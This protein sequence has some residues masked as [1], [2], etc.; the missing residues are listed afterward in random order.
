M[1]IILLKK[2]VKRIAGRQA[3][4]YLLNT[5]LGLLLHDKLHSSSSTSRDF[6]LQTLPKFSICAEIGVNEGDF[7]ER[8]LEIV[9]PKKLHL[10][11]PWKF[12]DDEFYKTTPYGSEKIQDQKMLDIRFENVTKR[13]TTE[14][15][16][17]QV[18]INRS[19]SDEILPKFDDNYF[20]W[21]YVDGNHLY[22]FVKKDLELCYMKIKNDGL[23]TGDDYYDGGWC[24]GGVKKA[25]DEFINTGL[26]QVIQ[27]KNNQF[28]LQK[29]TTLA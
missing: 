26:V 19:T 29:K 2:L 21:I 13:F 25:V 9:Q 11:D 6:L 4:V 12:E 27:L 16:K 8:I 1:M 10:I 15:K 20:D 3:Y 17:G 28:I 14:I 23:I 18:V 24:Q 5:K 7:S 22:E